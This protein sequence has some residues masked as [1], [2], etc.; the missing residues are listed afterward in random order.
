MLRTFFV[1]TYALHRIKTKT[2]NFLSAEFRSVVSATRT[3][4][5]NGGG[6]DR[7]A[8]AAPFCNAGKAVRNR[9][10]IGHS[11][12]RATSAISPASLKAFSPNVEINIGIRGVLGEVTT[13]LKNSP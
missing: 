13:T 1:K 9:Y 3:C 12:E 4:T 2:P 7:P 6:A 11:H 10:G 8:E 5:T